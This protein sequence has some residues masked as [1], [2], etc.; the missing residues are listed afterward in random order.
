MWSQALSEDIGTTNLADSLQMCSLVAHIKLPLW[1]MHFYSLQRNI[2]AAVLQMYWDAD[3]FSW[4]GKQLNCQLFR[5]LL[6]VLLAL[7]LSL[8]CCYNFILF[9]KAT[10][11]KVAEVSATLF[12]SAAQSGWTTPLVQLCGKWRGR[13]TMWP[14][15]TAAVLV[16]VTAVRQPWGEAAECGWSRT[17]RAYV[18]LWVSGRMS[19][20][21]L[22]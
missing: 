3:V 15:L 21:C 20:Q 18:W 14:F 10:D 8:Q 2:T 13:G 12:L 19:C 7:Q 16:P 9:I 4:V 1:N 17:W 11:D 22:F 6:M 5:M